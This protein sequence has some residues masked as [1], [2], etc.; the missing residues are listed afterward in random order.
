MHS[1]L[2]SCLLSTGCTATA[3]AQD[4]SPAPAAPARSDLSAAECEV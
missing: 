1:V 3:L 4:P 2:L